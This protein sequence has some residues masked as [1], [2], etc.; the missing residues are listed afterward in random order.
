ML[1]L[2]YC[3]VFLIEIRSDD[4]FIWFIFV[5]H[6]KFILFSMDTESNSETTVLIKIKLKSIITVTY[7]L[8]YTYF[9]G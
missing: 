3:V 5:Q 2:I 7:N 6:M 9:I 1:L 8:Y 4:Y